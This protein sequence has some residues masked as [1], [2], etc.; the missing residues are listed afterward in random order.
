MIPF[1]K[2]WLRPFKPVLGPI[3]RRLVR[4]TNARSRQQLSIRAQRLAAEAADA[5]RRTAGRADPPIRAMRQ[6]ELLE[7]AA[8]VPYYRARTVYMRRAGDIADELIARDELSTALEL[9]PHI[10]PL[11]VG[12]DVMDLR[13]AP[14]LRT[15]GRQ[16]AADATKAPWP[17][18]DKAYDL[19]VALQVFEHLGTRQADAFREVRRVARHAI[20]SL[21]IDW[22][23][24]DPRNCH[25]LLRHE[26]VLEWVAP[27]VPTR[28]VEG[29]GGHRKRLIYVFENLPPLEPEASAGAQIEEPGTADAVPADA[30]PAPEVATEA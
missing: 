10:Q 2:R 29:N 14:D 15:T 27:I 8:E 4:L 21:P 26:K 17:F 24:D 1:L 23:M 12:A 11:I 25:H 19:F 6:Y 28:V 30:V 20:L 22:E 7:L 18:P 16:V 13:L 3:Y 5:A 9:G